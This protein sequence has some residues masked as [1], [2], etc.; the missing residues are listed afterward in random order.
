MA[1]SLGRKTMKAK[2]RWGILA[3]LACATAALWCSAGHGQTTGPA[4]NVHFYFVQL[5]DTH[6]GEGNNLERTAAA[7][8]AINALPMPIEFV[9]HTGDIFDEGVNN[10]KMVK[11]GMAVLRALKPPIHFLPGNHDLPRGG[12]HLAASVKAYRDRVGPLAHKIECHGVVMIFFYVEPLAG[13]FQVEGYDPLTWLETSLKEAQG[14]PVIIF[15]HTPPISDSFAQRAHPGWPGEYVVK[16]N[17]LLSRYPV[18][19]VIAGHFHRNETHRQGKTTLF[20]S[21]PIAGLF[22]QGS[23]RIYE[24]ANGHLSYTTQYLERHWRS[25]AS[26]PTTASAPATRP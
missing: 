12:M 11:Q 23:Y 8:E 4:E 20:I 1:S 14:K 3:L 9:A 26:A 2:N 22:D 17:D 5:T 7:V 25:A 19:A 10:Q 24:Y 21:A 18:K 15:I 6:L 16:W 13:N